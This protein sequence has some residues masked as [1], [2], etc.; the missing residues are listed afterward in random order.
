LKKRNFSRCAWT[1]GWH[2]LFASRRR[3]RLVVDPV[4]Q[5]AG[6]AL[7]PAEAVAHFNTFWGVMAMKMTER[8]LSER[9]PRR[10]RLAFTLIEL[11]VV[12]AMMSLL[13]GMLLPAVQKVRE[14]AARASCQNNLKQIG[15]AL[16]NYHAAN[17]EFPLDLE[18]IGFGNET[19]GY[20]Y[21]YRRTRN[22]FN[23]QARPAAPGK[24]GLVW[25]EMD[26]RGRID[27]SPVP[28]AKEIQRR[29]F[30]RIWAGAMQATM[31]LMGTDS[32]KDASEETKALLESQLV[33]EMA[34]D[35]IDADGDGKVFLKEILE[36]EG[37]DSPLPF[38]EFIRQLR[39]ELEVG[40]GNESIDDVFIDGRIIT[41]K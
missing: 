22:G 21:D 37:E 41:A 38:N 8:S 2:S 28:G 23:I 29:M 33:R 14:A 31:E 12:I 36:L 30:D 19:G 40:A 7:L 27:Q 4:V 20:V 39:A 18:A 16:H 3:I 15:L 11:L 34:W 10:S 26:Q 32:L 9:T 1:A 6:T 24:T 35:K 13:I 5:P 25:F 17:N